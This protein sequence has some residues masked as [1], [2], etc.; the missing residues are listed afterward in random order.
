MSRLILSA[1]EKTEI[2]VTSI[3]PEDLIELSDKTFISKYG[4]KSNIKIVK[5]ASQ[6]VDKNYRIILNFITGFVA[7][8]LQSIPINSEQAKKF[9]FIL[10]SNIE[11]YTE[12]G[13]MLKK[14]DE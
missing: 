13:G 14:L 5:D 2:Y 11:K 4:R 9:G 3:F 12:I 10:D 8:H 6:G 1:K 7:Y